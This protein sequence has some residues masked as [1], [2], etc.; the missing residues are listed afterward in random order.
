MKV[1]CIVTSHSQIS[2]RHSLGGT[3]VRSVC[4]RS[5]AAATA[6]FAFAKALAAPG[7][8]EYAQGLKGSLEEMEEMT[9]AETEETSFAHRLVS[10]D[11]DRTATAALRPATTAAAAMRAAA[12]EAAARR[13]ARDISAM[14]TARGDSSPSFLSQRGILRNVLRVKSAFCACAAL[15][16]FASSPE[17]SAPVLGMCYCYRIHFKLLRYNTY[18]LIN[19]INQLDD[20]P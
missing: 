20:H 17:G 16:F 4:A 13:S 8:L 11:R 19:I 14:R 7:S 12:A 3:G 1:L 2:S 15:S 18:Q 10:F 9:S 6:W 5:A